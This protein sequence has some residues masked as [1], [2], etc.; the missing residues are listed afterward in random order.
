MTT[1]QELIDHIY[2]GIA[3]IENKP[4][5]WFW[6]QPN[7]TTKNYQAAFISD[8]SQFLCQGMNG[9]HVET[10]SISDVAV[11]YLVVNLQVSWHWGKHTHNTPSDFKISE[12][13]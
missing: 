4:I 1:F 11:N 6:E 8:V 10:V 7:L 13:V 2:P 5:E 3:Q 9:L 12:N